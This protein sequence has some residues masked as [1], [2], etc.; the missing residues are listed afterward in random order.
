MTHSLI[1]SGRCH[2]FGNDIPLDDGLIPFD[3]AIQRIDDPARLVPE[4]F[5]M[6]DPDFPR[7]VQPGDII[8]AGE[9]FGCGKPH[10]QGF[11]AMAALGLSVVCASMPYKTLRGAISK[12]VPVLTGLPAP[13]EAFRT[14]DRVAVDFMR[15]AISNLENAQCLALPP[16]SP[17]LADTVRRGGTR[18]MLAAWLNEH[19]NMRVPRQPA[20]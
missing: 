20:S 2:V 12:G 5:R 11:I 14:G 16:L 7:R 18:G 19:P 13:C 1:R 6:M 15:G 8:I 4:L 9:N 17:L 10:F 3:M